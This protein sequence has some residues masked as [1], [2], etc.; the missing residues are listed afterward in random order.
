[1]ISTSIAKNLLL[2]SLSDLEAKKSF[3]SPDDYAAD[4]I[5]VTCKYFIENERGIKSGPNAM[6]HFTTNYMNKSDDV[7]LFIESIKSDY[8][9]LLTSQNIQ[10]LVQNVCLNIGWDGMP[11]FLEDYFYK[12]HGI[13]VANDTEHYEF[14]SS[15][16]KRYQYDALVSTSNVDRNIS[17]MFSNNKKKMAVTITPTLSR[18]ESHFDHQDGDSFFYKGITDPDYVFEVH[19]DSYDDVDFFALELRSRNLRLEYF[20]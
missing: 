8:P 4:I 5:N 18:K 19:F 20:E 3:L 9:H 6:M 12:T 16:H 17:L 10:N 14:I 1:M 7:K 2:E 11:G 13:S 15:S